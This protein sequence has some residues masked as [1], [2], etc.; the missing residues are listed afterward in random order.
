MRVLALA[1]ALA[2]SGCAYHHAVFGPAL[3]AEVVEGQPESASAE[4]GGV[5]LTVHAGDWGGS[6]GD[7]EERLTPAEVFIEN[8]SGKALLITPEHFS[9][10]AP[11]GFRYQ[12]ME[13][14]VVQRLAAARRDGVAY[15]GVYGA[16][17]WPGTWGP[18]GFG[19]YPYVWWG[20]Y[21]PVYPYWGWVPPVRVN[22]QPSPRG[23]LEPGGSASLLLF[24]PVPS[25]ELP[26]FELRAELETEGGARL[27]AVRVQMVRK[28]AAPPAS[29]P[30]P[31]PEPPP[32]PSSPPPPPPTTTPV[33]PPLGGPVKRSPPA[34]RASHT[35]TDRQPGSIA[36][37][38]SWRRT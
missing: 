17:P 33:P 29:Q 11:N 2:L 4:A 37:S 21:G 3:P 16:Y 25:L 9:L 8:G 26:R 28:D 38:R 20:W 12:A 5:R 30:T 10:V 32:P 24:F 14:G 18:W 27:G 13:P 22:P 7:L 15:V 6:P 35:C 36:S 31:P 23:T 19:F 1:I 34:A